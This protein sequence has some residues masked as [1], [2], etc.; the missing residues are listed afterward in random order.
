MNL[1]CLKS[2]AYIEKQSK[3]VKRQ[4]YPGVIA[5]ERQRS[6]KQPEEPDWSVNPW[7]GLENKSYDEYQKWLII[8]NID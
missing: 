1:I 6:Y 2:M 3:P 8:N 5:A 4:H 7:K